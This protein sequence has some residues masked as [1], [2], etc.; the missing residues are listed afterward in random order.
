MNNTGVILV[1]DFNKLSNSYFYLLSIL[2]YLYYNASVII[3][4]TWFVY[5]QLLA[6]NV[7]FAV[8]VFPATSSFK[9]CSCGHT[10]SRTYQQVD[11]V[12][13]TMPF[14]CPFREYQEEYA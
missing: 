12:V 3:V 10:T 2:S 13:V 1:I 8:L 7:D 4:I 9:F 5:V 11:C 14:V 6:C